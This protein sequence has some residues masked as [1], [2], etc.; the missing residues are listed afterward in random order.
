M[1]SIAFEVLGFGIH[2][3]SIMIVLGLVCAIIVSN[4]EIKRQNINKNFFTNLI[5][6]VVLFGI[7]GARLY[8]VLFNWDY[9]SVNPIEILK[10]WHGGLAIHGGII[11]GIIVTII[12]TK[13]YKLNTFKMMDIMVVGVIIAQA[14]GRWGNF[15]N[16]EAYGMMTTRETL[17]TFHLPEFIIN[18]MCIDGLYY[19]PTFLYESLWNLAG[20]ILLLIL[21]RR[22]YNKI[23]E[24]T[25]IYLIWYSIGR[26]VIEHFRL[27][28]LMLGSF[29]MAQIMSIILIVVGVTIIIWSRRGLKI[30]NLYNQKNKDI[31]F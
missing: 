10:I 17:E 1:N 13:K 16:Q 3:Y 31:I 23:G 18:G 22:K 28:S 30:D 26:I 4:F 27:D 5:F 9:Y 29:K 19:H 14:I 15:F 24:I 20:F 7:I 2:W 25:G 12:Y 8:Y 21:R 6:Y 11:A